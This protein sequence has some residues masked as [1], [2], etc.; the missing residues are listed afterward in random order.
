MSSLNDILYKQ[1][2]NTAIVSPVGL[3]LVNAFLCVSEKNCLNNNA[4]SFSQFLMVMMFLFC[5][6]QHI[7]WLNI[8]IT[9][10]TAM[11]MHIFRLK[12]FIGKK[13]K[14]VAS[15]YFQ[16]QNLSWLKFIN[17]TYGKPSFQAFIHLLKAFYHAY[18]SIKVP[19]IS[20]I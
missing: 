20:K 2:G 7:I 5:L 18:V 13:S 8:K 9:W 3:L 14:I 10:I 17:T 4:L 12:Y 19:A 1:R 15:W 16:M 6:D 11:L